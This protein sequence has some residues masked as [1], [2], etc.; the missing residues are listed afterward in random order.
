[1]IQARSLKR[2]IILQFVTILLPLVAV[3][4]YQTMADHARARATDHA[5]QRAGFA[6]DVENQFVRFLDGIVDA[7]DSGSLASSARL[8]LDA[9]LDKLESLA[10]FDARREVATTRDRLRELQSLIPANTTIAQLTP[11]RM[12]INEAHEQIKALTKDAMAAEG[13]IVRETVAAARAQVY[14]VAAAALWSC[15]LTL[16]FITRMIRGLT[17]PLQRAVAAAR[18]IASGDLDSNPHLDTQGDIDGLIASLEHMRAGLRNYRE[19]LLD[20]QRVLETRVEERTHA[21]EATSAQSRVLAVEA[22]EANRAKSAFLANMSHEIRTP[23]NGVL[24]MTEVLLQTPLQAEQ[25]R[26]AETIY[27]SGQSLLGILNDILDFSK[28]EA[29]KLDLEQVDFNLWQIIEDVAGLLS[30]NAQQKGLELIC[31]IQTSVP[32]MAQGDPGRLRQLL[33]N[34]VGNAIK[35]TAQGQVT[36]VVSPL[37][38]AAAQDGVPWYRFAIIDSGIGMDGATLEKLFKPF[39]QADASTTRQYGGT[40]LG[41]AISK[42]LAELMGGKIGVSSEPGAGS[43]FWFEVPLAHATTQQTTLA[44]DIAAGTRILATDDNTTNLAVVQ[45]MLQPLRIH[46][47]VATSAARGIE[48][49]AAAAANAEPYA[50]AIIDMMMPGMD[51]LT[52]ARTL[53]ANPRLAATRLIMLTSAVSAEQRAQAYE[54]GINIY[55]AKPV[56]RAELLDAIRSSMGVAPTALATPPATLPATLSITTPESDKNPMMYNAPPPAAQSHVPYRLLLAEDNPVNQQIAL[57]MLKGMEFD[58]RVVANGQLAV[59][60]IHSEPFDLVLM[61]CQMPELDGFQATIQIR[62]QFSHRDLPIVAITA[63]AMDGDRE[64]CLAS[65]MDDYLSKPFK[66]EQLL[67]VVRKWISIE[68]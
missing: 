63:N 31:D 45:G 35:F 22:Q 50:I 54:S 27:R 49:L 42:H 2:Q 18:T 11:H 41:L 55:L 67:T 64:R 53:R 10:A 23:M 19:K 68:A 33:S 5:A 51:G 26:Y 17:D 4:A 6:G 52:M 21:L 58:V 7:V 12:R 36:I 34:L 65:G 57:A 15:L 28:I 32:V 16:L 56:R 1:M 25:R 60:A 9:S 59:D 47:D 62:K 20:N 39:S 46:L 38:H 66:K 8:A 44:W 43:T 40:G 29:G 30:Q 14:Y 24:G 48:L 13:I 3:L 61:D 37:A